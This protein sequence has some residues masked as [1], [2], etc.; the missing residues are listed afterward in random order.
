MNGSDD[1]LKS[2]PVFH[3]QNEELSL[4][5]YVKLIRGKIS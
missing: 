2:N 4:A 1:K 3:C 5:D